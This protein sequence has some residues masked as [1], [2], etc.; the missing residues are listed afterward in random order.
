MTDNTQPLDAAGGAASDAQLLEIAS[1]YRSTYQHGGTTFDQFDALGFARALLTSNSTEKSDGGAAHSPGKLGDGATIR[2]RK[3]GEQ[4]V[5]EFNNA[6][7]ITHNRFTG[8]PR[9]QRDIDSDPEGKLLVD[10]SK[11]LP[12]APKAHG[13]RN[14]E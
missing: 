7:I 9:D 6:R 13:G 8:K 11:P 14:G 2:C 3:C 12:T 5:I 1:D 10:P 4:N